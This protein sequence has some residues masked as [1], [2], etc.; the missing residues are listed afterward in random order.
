VSF[1]NFILVEVGDGAEIAN[2]LREAEVIVRPVAPYQL[3]QYIRVTYGNR[4]ENR[5]FLKALAVVLG[6]GIA[7]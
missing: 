7:Q 5:K 3:P 1:A 2:K 6:R 4:S